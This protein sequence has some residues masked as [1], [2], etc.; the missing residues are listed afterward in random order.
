M[1]AYYK[2]IKSGFPSIFVFNGEDKK[3]E[4]KKL[5]SLLS[6][7]VDENSKKVLE[8][9]NAG[10]LDPDDFKKQAN[11]RSRLF[12]V[13]IHIPITTSSRSSNP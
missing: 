6:S 8:K 4:N 2:D 5:L 13:S 1:S 3:T 10:A 9:I 12:Q 11:Y 7:V